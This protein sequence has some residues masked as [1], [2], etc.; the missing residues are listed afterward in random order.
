MTK[1]HWALKR[2]HVLVGVSHK[3]GVELTWDTYEPALTI[4]VLNVWVVLEWWPKENDGF[5]Y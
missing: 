4:H 2:L 1:K 5:Y 3:W